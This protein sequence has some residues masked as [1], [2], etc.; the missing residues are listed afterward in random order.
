MIIRATI[1]WQT[2]K[3]ALDGDRRFWERIA[4]GALAWLLLHILMSALGQGLLVAA[5]VAESP[6]VSLVVPGCR[7]EST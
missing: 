3:E 7:R 1:R 4:A 6:G 5:G 2:A